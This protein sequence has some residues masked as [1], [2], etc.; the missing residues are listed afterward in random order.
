[1][2]IYGRGSSAFVIV[3]IAVVILKGIALILIVKDVELGQT[4]RKHK[5]S[6]GLKPWQFTFSC[7]GSMF[8]MILYLST[9]SE[10]NSTSFKIKSRSTVKT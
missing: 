10:P 7:H 1:M 2:L 5:E 9:V 3:F 4:L 8:H 6:H